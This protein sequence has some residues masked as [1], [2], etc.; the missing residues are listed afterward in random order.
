MISMTSTRAEAGSS[1]R[2]APGERSVVS[3]IRGLRWWVGV[4]LAAVLAAAGITVDVLGTGTV[5]IAYGVGLAAGCLLATAWVRRS[6]LFAP[7]VQPPLLVAV[8]VPTVVAA[9]G[10]LPPSGGAVSVVLAI[11]GPFI[12]GFP[13]MAVT[14]VA[15]LALGW[16]RTKLQPWSRREVERRGPPRRASGPVRAGA[17]PPDD[18]PARRGPVGSSPDEERLLGSPTSRRPSSPDRRSDPDARRR[19]REER[20]R[21][22]RVRSERRPE[23]QRREDQRR[24]DDRPRPPR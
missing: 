12:N 2:P 15:C 11:G 13:T 3:T 22:Q 8:L 23:D 7:M 17:R 14:T 1:G 18:R 21:E 6:E 24:R 5:G 16:A 19:P 4:V 10:S 9:T 20:M